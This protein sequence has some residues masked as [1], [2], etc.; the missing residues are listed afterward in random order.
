MDR[1]IMKHEET[2][3]V[4]RATRR[5]FEQV[6]S[7]KGWKEVDPETPLTAGTVTEE[8]TKQPRRSRP[9]AEPQE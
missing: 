4:A 1:V 9:A 7:E 6:W 2:G 5:A 8:P 3:G